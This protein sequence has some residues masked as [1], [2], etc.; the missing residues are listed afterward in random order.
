MDARGRAP[1]ADW[2]RARYGQRP[3]PRAPAPPQRHQFCSGRERGVRAVAAAAGPV[4]GTVGLRAGVD[5]LRTIGLHTLTGRCLRPEPARP[6]PHGAAAACVRR[7]HQRTVADGDAH[8]RHP[9][10]ELDGKRRWVSRRPGAEEG[11]GVSHQERSR[12]RLEWHLGLLSRSQTALNTDAQGLAGSVLYYYD[13]SDVCW[14]HLVAERARR[15]RSRRPSMRA[16]AAGL[17]SPIPSCDQHV[18]LVIPAE[19]TAFHSANEG[20]AWTSVSFSD[21]QSPVTVAVINYQHNGVVR[22]RAMIG[23][24]RVGPDDG[25][26]C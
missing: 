4:D 8:G 22:G 2:L 24:N 26:L 3:P 6:R 17:T 5:L 16:A 11:W 18:F 10:Q 9:D 12:G 7:W 19:G 1:R 20:L 13:D 15:W 25:L 23:P 21:Y 14:Q